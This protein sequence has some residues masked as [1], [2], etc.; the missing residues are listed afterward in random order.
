MARGTRNLISTM[1]PPRAS[2]FEGSLLE[3]PISVTPPTFDPNEPRAGTRSHASEVALGHPAPGPLYPDGA[4]PS[5]EDPWDPNDDHERFLRD[6]DTTTRETEAHVEEVARRSQQRHQRRAQAGFEFDRMTRN[7]LATSRSGIAAAAASNLVGEGVRRGPEGSASVGHT[8]E[9]MLDIFNPNHNARELAKELVLLEHH[10]V[11]PPKHCPDCIRKHLIT[12]EGLAEEAVGLDA[13]PESRAYFGAAATEI[14][15]VCRDVI[16]K[17]DRGQLQQRIRRLRKGMLK[18]GFDSVMSQESRPSR[19][20]EAAPQAVPA[21]ASDVRAAMDQFPLGVRVAFR[22]EGTW[23]AGKVTGRSTIREGEAP[24][25]AV[26][27]ISGD[28]SL[29]GASLSP[30]AVPVKPTDGI[31]RLAD[32]PISGRLQGKGFQRYAPDGQ[33]VGRPVFLNDQQSLMAD[34]IQATWMNVIGDG[35]EICRGV[36][37][38]TNPA[39]VDG[40]GCS[41]SVMDQLVRAAIVT[42]FYESNLDPKARR[43]TSVEDSLGLFQLN[44]KGGLGT[45]QP[46]A[47]LL[48]P[49]DNARIAASEV[50]R[51]IRDFGTLIARE[52][53]LQPTSVGQ[54]VDVITRRIQRPQDPDLAAQIRSRTADLVWPPRSQASV[55]SSR[56][57]SVGRDPEGDRTRTFGLAFPI[58]TTLVMPSDRRA[59]AILS[60]SSSS[61]MV[62]Q[63]QRVVSRSAKAWLEAGRRTKSPFPFM[64]AAYLARAATDM[65]TYQAALG[66][67]STDFASTPVG[68]EAKRMLAETGGLTVPEGGWTTQEKIVGAAAGIFGAIA[69]ASLLRARNPRGG[70]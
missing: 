16:G 64:R 36:A 46:P 68:A 67:L 70:L 65:G 38:I 18:R 63:E 58:V 39:Q 48:D 60:R 37:G 5:Y 29:P 61:S 51:R 34:I 35:R 56:L 41:V 49:V 1:L 7:M 44:R 15:E 14:R 57:M 3:L 54:W 22:R 8:H 53:N 4:A 23:Y 19:M 47:M 69:V 25:L 62:P 59:R 6:V 20:G 10:I 52:A 28:R 31:I 32:S 13:D 50:W 11:H 24:E 43:T 12:A 21:S 30:Y 55:A 40:V 66:V 45:N 26:V 17:K 2:A 33:I 42:A 27:S 9:G